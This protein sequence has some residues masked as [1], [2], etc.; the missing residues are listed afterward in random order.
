MPSPNDIIKVR[1]DHSADV[2]ELEKLQALAVAHEV[3]AGQGAPDQTPLS[4]RQRISSS[5]LRVQPLDDED[6]LVKIV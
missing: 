4:S 2:F 5:T 3:A 1:E 6:V